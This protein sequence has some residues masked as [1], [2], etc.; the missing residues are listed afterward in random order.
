MYRV[1]TRLIAALPAC[2]RLPSGAISEVGNSMEYE[3]V[4]HR[5]GNHGQISA[6]IQTS[7]PL[8]GIAV[9]HA[10]M[11]EK[12]DV[13]TLTG[14]HLIIENVETCI[15]ARADVFSRVIVHVYTRERNRAAL[16]GSAEQP[17]TPQKR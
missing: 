12:Q 7:M 15:W 4:I 3:Y 5:P 1:E 8:P 17:A 13:S 6:H 2:A 9:G 10:L 16:S 14:H 11:L